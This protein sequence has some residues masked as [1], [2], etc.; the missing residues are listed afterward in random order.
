MKWFWLLR[1]RHSSWPGKWLLHY[2][3]PITV[4]QFSETK[5]SICFSAA[6]DDVH[7]REKHDQFIL[8]LLL[9]MSISQENILIN[10]IW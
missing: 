6:A 4:I 3:I 1:S 8:I 9:N 5:S 10:A 7:L 2:F